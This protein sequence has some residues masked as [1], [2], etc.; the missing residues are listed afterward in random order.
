M[1]LQSTLR[2]SVQATPYR[3]VFQST[4]H[5]SALA[6]LHCIHGIV[7]GLTLYGIVDDPI[8]SRVLQGGHSKGRLEGRSIY[9]CFCTR[10]M[11]TQHETRSRKCFQQARKHVELIIFYLSTQYSIIALIIYVDLVFSLYLQSIVLL[12]LC[13]CVVYTMHGNISIDIQLVCEKVVMLIL[14]FGSKKILKY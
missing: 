3:M 10:K 14:N 8:E 13:R 12:I 2:C 4:L 7:E 6:A 5:C 1:V 11:V 9:G